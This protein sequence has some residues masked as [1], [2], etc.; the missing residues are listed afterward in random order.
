MKYHTVTTDG[1]TTTVTFNDGSTCPAVPSNSPHYHV[2]AHRCG[3][4]DDL[5]RYCFE[6]ELAHCV[7]SEFFW[8]MPS[9]VL[10]AVADGHPMTGKD[11]AFEEL[12]AQTLQ[13]FVR[14]G[15]RPIIG[16]VR[17]DDLKAAFL[18]ECK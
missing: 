13:R 9:P 10:S 6:H 17:W 18:E 8:N 16:G 14:A 5:G 7:V 2:I 15:E 11:S 1:W 12:M 3:Y 4:G